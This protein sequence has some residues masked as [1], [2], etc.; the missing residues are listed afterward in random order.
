MWLFSKTQGAPESYYSPKTK[1]IKDI[2]LS[3]K[4][5]ATKEYKTVH[6]SEDPKTS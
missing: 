1:L 4:Y 6:C 2:K 5:L 3:Y